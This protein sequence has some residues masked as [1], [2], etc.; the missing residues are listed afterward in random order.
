MVVGLEG[1]A[2]LVS[3]RRSD[4]ERASPRHPRGAAADTHKGLGGVLLDRGDLA[5]GGVPP[6]VYVDLEP[7]LSRVNMSPVTQ[8]LDVSGAVQRRGMGEEVKASSVPVL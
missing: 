1:Q 4:D 2:H 5:Q 7:A 8:T 3:S 6:P